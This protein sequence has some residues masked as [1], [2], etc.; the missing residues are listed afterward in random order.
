MTSHAKIKYLDQPITVQRNLERYSYFWIELE[1]RH[2][3]EMFKSKR[4]HKQFCSGRCRVAAHRAKVAT[5]VV[6]E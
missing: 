2:C 3:G 1:C 6:S 5:G 4:I